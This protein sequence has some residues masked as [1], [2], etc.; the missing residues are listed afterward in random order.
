MTDHPYHARLRPAL[1]SWGRRCR[2]LRTWALA[3]TGLALLAMKLAAAVAL[4]RWLMLGQLG[5]WSL[6]LAIW[7]CA[8]TLGVA[9]WA[10]RR[11]PLPLSRL[12]RQAEAASALPADALPTVVSAFERPVPGISSEL[13]ELL[14]LRL[15]DCVEKLAVPKSLRQ[16]A[17]GSTAAAAVLWSALAVAALL[18]PD[19][20]WATSRV[21]LPWADL[22]A[23]YRQHL[24]LLPQ[25]VVL[26]QGAP[27][28]WSATLTRPPQGTAPELAARGDVP[29]IELS[30]DRETWSRLAMSPRG[31]AGFVARLDVVQRDLWYRAVYGNVR[32]PVYHARVH[33]RPVVQTAELEITYAASLGGAVVRV[34]LER[35]PAGVL[36]ATL[37][38]GSAVRLG[39]TLTEPPS[40]VQLGG[41]GLLVEAR[42]EL[43]DAKDLWINLPPDVAALPSQSLRLTLTAET[44]R[45]GSVR[46]SILLST[47]ADA[48]PVVRLIAPRGGT[49]VA[50]TDEIDVVLVGE[51]D[52]GLE[53][54]ELR[55]RTARGT[56]T[57]PLPLRNA[58]RRQRLTIPV[59]LQTLS[60]VPGETLTVSAWVRDTSGRQAVSDDL[61][62]RVALIPPDPVIAARLS[63]LTDLSRLLAAARRAILR[64]ADALD[65]L[66]RQPPEARLLSLATTRLEVAAAVESLGR[67]QRAWPRLARAAGDARFA[68]AVMALADQTVSATVVA[69]D[70]VRASADT[71][72]QRLTDLALRLRRAGGELTDN[73]LRPVERL[74]RG[75]A[76]RL[77]LATRQAAQSLIPDED[78][79]LLNLDELA[80]SEAAAQSPEQLNRLA[81]LGLKAT[82]DTPADALAA[83]LDLAWRIEALRP[84]VLPQRAADLAAI[85]AALRQTPA[86]SVSRL[87]ALL[88]R[89]EAEH[90]LARMG[91]APDA[92]VAADAGRARD[93]LA[94]L[95]RPRD[96]LAPP[97][98]PIDLTLLT[99]P[100]ARDD[101]DVQRAGRLL[102][103]ARRQ[104][105]LADSLS[106]TNRPTDARTASS[107]EALLRDSLRAIERE[108]R[109]SD[110]PPLPA[111]FSTL[112]LAEPR[113]AAL[114]TI[115]A[116]DTQLADAE[117]TL[118]VLADTLAAREKLLS[119]P[120][121]DEAGLGDNAR[122]LTELA[123]A[124]PLRQLAETRDELKR[125][126]PELSGV[127]L[128]I[129]R[130][131]LPVLSTLI[132][133]IDRVSDTETPSLAQLT[134]AG[135]GAV[136]RGREQLIE[137]RL[138]LVRRDPMLVARAGLTAAVMA[139]R[140]R[141]PDPVSAMRLTLAAA[142][143]T[144]F[145]AE[146]ARRSRN[147][148][149]LSMLPELNAYAAPHDNDEPSFESALS[150]AGVDR[151][152]ALDP[153]RPP[154]GTSADAAAAA[155]DLVA[156]RPTEEAIRS[157]PGS[158]ALREAVRTYFELLEQLPV[159][160]QP[161]NEGRP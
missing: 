148:R 85:A 127:A 77:L 18:R 97:A 151:P 36:H 161:P 105:E 60:V 64:A 68:D 9:S 101:P 56:T 15:V 41:P 136:R 137:L 13:A 129:D 99:S 153:S 140:R 48:D 92:S 34:T 74:R 118:L 96:R 27:L 104:R 32:T 128:T 120:D 134:E 112:A 47:L 152:R 130:T 133:A 5:R 106:R 88:T 4:E 46:E 84:D 23:P 1:L 95:T 86:A 81:G 65:D 149:L 138:S 52:V 30:Y 108:S 20:L 124:L 83:R 102:D 45:G 25:N 90:T 8:V 67:A 94:R 61:T 21:L 55:L 43:P 110:L 50:P 62:L 117:Q 10:S 123:A 69:E 111:L 79:D 7:S 135:L 82:P 57:V 12:A 126:G 100:A 19:L 150:P 91:S 51:D 63:S 40:R 158:D 89:L 2:R 39:V 109:S 33:T 76:A 37:P 143:A 147:L 113:I 14:A 144:E 132:P 75:D 80:L 125:I 53:S 157:L 154:T 6:G 73:V 93:E 107:L 35:D 59:Q 72:S 156:R 146:Q 3:A 141:D 78:A 119:R 38:V 139:L 24:T 28:Q 114:R 26:P 49:T 155:R 44:A 115:V 66:A 71:S 29:L 87:V 159:A 131:L 70:A 121:R 54:G 11:S 22:D 116:A 16:H 142:E 58:P 103:L 160:R 145:A 122:R 31:S 42:P 98:A 17:A